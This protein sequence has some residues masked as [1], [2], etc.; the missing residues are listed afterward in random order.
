MQQIEKLKKYG[1]HNRPYMT[2][3]QKSKKKLPSQAQVVIIGGGIIGSSI[4]Y[5]LTKMGWKDIILLE[6]NQLAAGNTSHAAGQVKVGGFFD[7]SKISMAKYTRELYQSLEA[8]TGRSTGYKSIGHLEFAASPSRLHELRRVA[9]FDRIFDVNVEE[10]SPTDVKKIWPLAET[11]DILAGF[12]TEEGG[13]VNPTDATMALAKGAQMGGVQIFEE[14]EVIGI[15]KENGQVS[16]VITNQGEIKAEYVVNCAGMW[17]REIGKLA[18]V[19]V[20]VQAAENYY[21]ITDPIDEINQDLP[22]LVDLDRYAYYREEAGGILLRLFEPE[23]IPWGRDSVSQEFNF[24]EKNSPWDRIRPYI[25]EAM[26]RI[27]IMQD[28]GVQKLFCRPETFT[29]DLGPLMGEAPEL[30]N[31]FIAAGFNSE[32]TLLA[33]GV[34]RIMAHWIEAGY[35]DV[36]IS[37]IDVGRMFAYENTLKFLHDRTIKI[38]GL[39]YKPGYVNSQYESARNIRKS[40]FHERMA[41]AGAYFGSYAGWEY[42]DWFA[43]QGVKPKVEYSWGRQN[44]FEYAAAEH[45]ATREGVIL[46]DY[47]AMAELLVHGRDAEKVLNQICANNI[48]IPIGRCVYTQCLNERGTLEADVTVTRIAED[49]FLVLTGDGTSLAVETWFRKNTPP[50]AHSVITNITSGLSALNIHGPKSRELLSRVTSADM[51]NEAFP[52]LTM[53][54][55][56]IGYALVQALRLSYTGEL[57]WELFIPTEFSLNVFDTLVDAGKEF[58]LVFAGFQA[59]ETLRLEKAYRDYGTDMGNLDTPLEVGL[60][61]FVDFDKPGGFIGRD[62]LLKHKESGLLKY[63]VVQF[64]LEDPEPMLYHNE[65]IYRN[66]EYAGTIYVAGYGHTLG[67]SVGLGSIE[68]E[69]GVT[70]DYI[71]SGTYEI[72]IAGERYPAKASLRPMYDPKSKRVKS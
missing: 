31:F 64:L 37:G 52:Y 2:E 58:G 63:R 34:G 12:Y 39:M 40:A 17:A 50:D 41:D 33:G 66:G 5:H 7:E 26:K 71:K 57:G 56:D 13:R 11:D 20:P 32:G 54:E 25:E 70:P 45:R 35:P 15:N 16:G 72:D 60:R 9:A 18:G 19:N 65:P 55:I 10:I 30:K 3:K 8:E 62:A 69:N 68:N 46:M 28:V 29:P 61:M 24:G 27:P 1:I 48:S 22:V 47:S 67:A 4:A 49:K 53:Q 59:L 6:R 51:S 43:P 42:P 44:W 21:L 36:D 38:P 14:C 23:A